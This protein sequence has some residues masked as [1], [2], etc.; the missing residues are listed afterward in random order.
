MLKQ[1]TFQEI[2]DK[3]NEVTKFSYTFPFLAS[4]MSI[5]KTWETANAGT[6]NDL[7]SK[8]TELYEA[9]VSKKDG[10]F[11]FLGAD[12]PKFLSTEAE[13]RFNEDWRNFLKTNCTI[14][15]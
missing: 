1:T 4:R 14:V 15:L 8:Q 12:R 6:I 3:Q 2:F 13:T 10:K 7:I 9:N 5:I 11:E